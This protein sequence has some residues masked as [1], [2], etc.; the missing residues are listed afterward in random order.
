MPGESGLETCARLKSEPRTANIPIIFL[1]AL[2]DVSSKVTGLRMG[3]VDYISKP[4]HGE[5]LLARV[6]V[7]LRIS[8]ANRKQVEEQRVRLEQLRAA[9]EAILTRPEDCPEAAFGV[10]FRPLEEAGGD[11]YD[12][13]RIAPDVVGYFA[14]DISGHGVSASFLTAAIKALLRQYASPLFSPE[15]SMRGIDAVMRQLLGEEQYLTACYA[16]LNQ[17]TRNLAVVSAG[18]PPLVVVTA[19]GNARAIEVQSEPL[20]VFGSQVL[21]QKEVRLARQ[22]RFFLY[23]DGLIEGCP[24]SG[25]EEGL[26]QLMEACIRHRNTPIE[27]APARI[28]G[29][30]RPDFSTVNDD[31]LLLAVEVRR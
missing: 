28:A 11:F 17:R 6:R 22:D 4:V 1:S 18:H 19:T 20:G 12:V 31:L 10:F 7:H 30:L 3:G 8:A 16:R 26:E 21:Q 27:Q 14:A 23:S 29:E 5:E 25:R 2:D 13:V 15:D 24:G 9:Q